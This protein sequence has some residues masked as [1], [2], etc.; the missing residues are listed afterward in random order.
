[1]IK[2]AGSEFDDYSISH[3]IITLGLWINWKRFFDDLFLDN[4]LH[5]YWIWFLQKKKTL[6]ALIFAKNEFCFYSV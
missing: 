3:K 1:M 6:P 5:D 2:D 4:N